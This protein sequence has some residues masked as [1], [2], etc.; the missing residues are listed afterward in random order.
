MFNKKTK[1]KTCIKSTHKLNI[2]N[3]EIE[4]I[5]YL[6][7]NYVYTQAGG[8]KLIFLPAKDTQY[9]INTE[10]KRLEELNL[11]A[12]MMQMNQLKGMIGEIGKEEKTEDG[13]RYISL[14]NKEESPAQLE[15]NLQIISFSGLE[16]TA[17]QKF[18]EYQE[19]MQMFRTNLNAGEIVKSSKSV[20]KI[21]GQEQIINMELIE[22][23]NYTGDISEIDAY[24]NYKIAK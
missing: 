12:Q 6:T 18:N 1:S 16:K 2:N 8:K 4:Q 17:S 5:Q 24:G 7:E 20:F 23:E 21:N 9:I 13:V 10:T 22:I 14:K 15:V 3:K 19:A 11:T